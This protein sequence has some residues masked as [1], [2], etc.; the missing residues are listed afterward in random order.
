[1]YSLQGA[2]IA[3]PLGRFSFTNTSTLT[4]NSD[5]SIDFYLQ[6]TQPATAAQQANWLPTAA[7]QGFEVT[8]RLFAP[9]TASI[10]GILNG[11]AWQPPQITVAAP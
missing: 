10:S 2:L 9:Q 8:W 11:S 1:M 4:H 3:N 7:G 5:G 6:S